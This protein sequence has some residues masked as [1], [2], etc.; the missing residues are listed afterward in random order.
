[1]PHHPA[2][3]SLLRHAAAQLAPARASAPKAEGARSPDR[4]GAEAEDA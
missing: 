1:M 4:P 2:L 3:A